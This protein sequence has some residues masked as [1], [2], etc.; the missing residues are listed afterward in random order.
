MRSRGYYSK[1]NKLEFRFALFT[2]GGILVYVGGL[3]LLAALTPFGPWIRE[4]SEFVA[5][6]IIYV[7]PAAVF[8]VA[9]GFHLR[10]LFRLRQQG[11][12]NV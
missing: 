5:P 9:A 12:S 8:L 2:I 1:R 11:D 3:C 10:S 4:Q 6:G 7:I